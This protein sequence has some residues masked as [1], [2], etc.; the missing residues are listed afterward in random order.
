[1]FTHILITLD[2]SEY[3]ERALAYAEDLAR[4]LRARVTLLAVIPAEA[5]AVEGGGSEG[6]AERAE[7]WRA[8]L[9]R[10]ADGLRASGIAPVEVEVRRGS[11]ARTIADFAR[12]AHV[13]LIAM[14][15]QGLSA[16]GDE[17]L[18]SVASKVLQHAP[19]PVFMVRVQRPSPPRTPAEERWQSE[20]GRN[21]G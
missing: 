4:P 18:G 13:D 3:G 10:H 2:G 6:A 8:Y 15:T 16:Q 17:G 7:R 21:V 19:C 20:G 9:E 12:E 5:P 11:P 14:S 1:V